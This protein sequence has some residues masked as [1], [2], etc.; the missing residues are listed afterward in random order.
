MISH[1]LF[2]C[3]VVLLF[4]A[5]AALTPALAQKK[6][7]PHSVSISSAER[8]MPGTAPGIRE[9]LVGLEGQET[10]LGT[11][12]DVTGDYV[13]F[14]ADADTLIYPLATLQVVK[15]LKPEEGD[16]RKIEIRFLSKD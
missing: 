12:I 11:L 3:L 16:A 10:N 4:T 7:T 13:V 14:H 1:R 9:I 2:S 15:F 6:A 5:V 8:H